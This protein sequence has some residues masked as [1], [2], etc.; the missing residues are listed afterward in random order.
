MANDSISYWRWLCKGSGGKPGYVRVLDIWIAA[1]II[2]GFILSLVVPINLKDAANTVLLP[3]VGML[4]GLSFA[5][6]GNSLSLL[7]SKEIDRLADY[8]EGGFQD[9]VYTYQTA[10]LVILITL[11]L[12]CIAGLQIFD[13]VWPTSAHPIIYF[14]LK[15]G[16]FAFSS[17]SIREC[18]QVVQGTQL[19]LVVQREIKKGTKAKKDT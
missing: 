6:A 5:W 1:H 12:W 3:V 7:Q 16:L 17:L 2:V 18:W 15:A 11:I 10:V 14:F 13:F 9:Y 19:L 8:H 4:I